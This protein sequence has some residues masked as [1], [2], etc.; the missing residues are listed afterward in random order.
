MRARAGILLLPLAALLLGA[1]AR[2]QGRPDMV[3]YVL[4]WFRGSYRSPVLCTFDGEP[5]QG[6]RRVLVVEGPPQ[7][8]RRVDRIQFQDLEARDA[9]RCRSP[10][11]GEA[12]NVIGSLLVTYTQQRL[13][14]DTP[15]RDFQQALRGGR[16]ELEIVSGRLRLGPTSTLPERLPEIDFAGGRAE[17]GE[18]DPA[19]DAARFLADFGPR[20]RVWLG[21]EARDGTRIEMPMVEF[22]RR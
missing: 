1:A 21:I 17:I 8:E 9:E 6:V 11:G 16:L 15:K 4:G 2:A 10:L 5:R 19:S 18:V 20:K 14:S 7:A 3:D 12:P 13:R 22:E